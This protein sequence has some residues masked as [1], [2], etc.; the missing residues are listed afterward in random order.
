MHLMLVAGRQNPYHFIVLTERQIYYRGT[1]LK[2]EFWCDLRIKALV[3]FEGRC[4]I[5]SVEDT[6]NDAH[7]IIYPKNIYEKAQ[8]LTVLCRRC[9]E[10]V[11]LIQ[12]QIPKNIGH[13]YRN[14]RD[15]SIE[16]KTELGIPHT[17]KSL[18]SNQ[19]D[20]F[21]KSLRR[22]WKEM[23]T[24]P[25]DCACCRK[26]D[27]TVNKGKLPM[28]KKMLLCDTCCAGV[29]SWQLF[30]QESEDQPRNK[31]SRSGYKQYMR[32]IREFC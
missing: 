24:V 22:A 4:S 19:E 26:H 7:H 17:G 23:V 1:F 5:C 27:S 16:I 12:G 14:F 13:A 11:H 3:M 9:H 6:S 21:G 20:L 10:K 15:A 2:S 8:H 18:R 31:S 25:T 30:F 28:A 32:C 29:R